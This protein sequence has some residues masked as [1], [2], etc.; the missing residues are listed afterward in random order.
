MNTQSDFTFKSQQIALIAV[1]TGEKRERLYIQQ[2]SLKAKAFPGLYELPGG[3]V[4]LGE[5]PLDAAIRE[6]KEETALDLSKQKKQFLA[7]A[8]LLWSYGNKLSEVSEKKYLCFFPFFIYVDELK[9][10]KDHKIQLA[11]PGEWIDWHIL[12][13]ELQKKN[14]KYQ[15]PEATVELFKRWTL[16]KE[17]YQLASPFEKMSFL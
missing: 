8:P 4:E 11:G 9:E 13:N 17:H 1:L 15:F 16:V 12:E 5:S 6:L 7:D 2:R 14:S 3:K 10:T